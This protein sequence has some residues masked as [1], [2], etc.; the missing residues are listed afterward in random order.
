MHHFSESDMARLMKAM[1]RAQSAADRIY[2]SLSE[3]SGMIAIAA[4]LLVLEMRLDGA[5]STEVRSKT[6]QWFGEWVL[7]L[8][9]HDAG[10]QGGPISIQVQ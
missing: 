5:P 3:E 10:A 7:A 4:L 6:L 1:P 9:Q 8:Q 2:Q